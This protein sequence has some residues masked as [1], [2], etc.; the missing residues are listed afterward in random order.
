M[1]SVSEKQKRTMAAAAHSKEFAKKVGIPQK[2]AKEFN[3]ADQ[4]ASVENV[5]I[6][7]SYKDV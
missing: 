3:K 4:K 2:V 7:A 1:P 5:Q 6:G